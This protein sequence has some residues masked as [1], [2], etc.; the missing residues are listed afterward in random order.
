M[1]PDEQPTVVERTTLITRLVVMGY[2]EVNLTN[3]IVDSRTRK[4]IA[5]A[6][7][8]VQRMAPRGLVI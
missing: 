6:L 4:E 7:I 1:N 5:E 2:L 3:V 8:A